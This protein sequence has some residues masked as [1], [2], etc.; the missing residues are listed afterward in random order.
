MFYVETGYVMTFI[1]NIVL[2]LPTN[3]ALNKVASQPSQ[4]QYGS[5][6]KAVDGCKNND[7]RERCCSHTDLTYEP[8]WHVDLGYITNVFRIVITRRWDGKFKQIKFCLFVCFCI[9]I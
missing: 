1:I 8:W 4:W 5:A 2:D 9:E 7:W 3:L 6:D